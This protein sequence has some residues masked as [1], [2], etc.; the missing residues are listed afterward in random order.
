MRRLDINKNMRIFS[1]RVSG[2]KGEH[3]ISNDNRQVECHFPK[4]IYSHLIAETLQGEPFSIKEKLSPQLLNQLIS[5]ASYQ[6][7]KNNLKPKD[8]THSA[9][10]KSYFELNDAYLKADEEEDRILSELNIFATDITHARALLEKLK[11]IYY[12]KFYYL[13]TSFQKQSGITLSTDCRSIF[14]P[15]FFTFHRFNI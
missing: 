3:Y 14:L 5:E 10:G 15:S 8:Q 2:I 13:T 4:G 11:E 1:D 9:Y 12:L 7:I 6:V